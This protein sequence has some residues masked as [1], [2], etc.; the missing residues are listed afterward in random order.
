M[1]QRSKGAELI[2]AI[3]LLYIKGRMRR[4]YLGKQCTDSYKNNPP[5]SAARPALCLQ[6]L[7]SVAPRQ[8]QHA[9]CEVVTRYHKQVNGP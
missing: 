3:R 6:P 9:G 1:E 5:Q 2:S 7:G 8:T 4:I